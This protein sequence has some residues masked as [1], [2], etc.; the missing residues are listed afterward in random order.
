MASVWLPA[1]ASVAA[2]STLLAVAAG[3]FVYIAAS[4]LVPE[5]RRVRGLRAGASQLLWIV[6]GLA[7][8]TIPALLE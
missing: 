5:L 4:D 6:L 7:L 2:V 3:G 8:M 1:L